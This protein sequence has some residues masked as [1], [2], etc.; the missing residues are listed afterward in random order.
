MATATLNKPVISGDKAPAPVSKK[1][2]AKADVEAKRSAEVAAEAAAAVSVQFA[3]RMAKLFDDTKSTFDRARLSHQAVA[4]GASL[5]I[6]ADELSM[7]RARAAYPEATEIELDYYASNVTG[8]GGT[9]ISKASLHAYASAW[10]SISKATLEH[11]VEVVGLAFRLYSK[12]GTASGRKESEVRCAAM[13]DKAAARAE[14]IR[15]A[16]LN[17]R[18]VNPYEITPKVAPKSEDTSEDEETEE[19]PQ[20][21]GFSLAQVLSTIEQASRQTWNTKERDRILEAFSAFVDATA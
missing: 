10:E 4:K 16:H 3:G 12:G 14:Y 9:Q 13:E 7:I 2:S 5:T 21:K 6:V 18:G 19:E 8:K 11:D 1:A 17:L 15:A 20:S